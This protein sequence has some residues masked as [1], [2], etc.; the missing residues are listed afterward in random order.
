M[1]YLSFILFFLVFQTEEFNAKVTSVEDA[2]SFEVTSNGKK[3]MIRLYG[4]DCPEDGQAFGAKAK[5]FTEAICNGKEVT[6][7][8]VTIDTKNR[9]VAHVILPDGKS[10]ARELLKAGY[11]WHYKQYSND[12]DL[13]Q[14]EQEARKQKKGLWI[15]TNPMSPWDYKKAQKEKQQQVN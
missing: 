2:D 3:Y 7:Q 11:A 12:K 9:I 1:Q 10:L 5:L 14:L 13:D 4:V 8:K 15:E 6:I